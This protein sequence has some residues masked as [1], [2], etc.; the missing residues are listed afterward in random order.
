MRRCPHVT[1]IETPILNTGS[2]TAAGL[3]VLTYL[4][5]SNKLLGHLRASL[6]GTHTDFGSSAAIEA[7]DPLHNVVPIVVVC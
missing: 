3:A 1:A 7:F 5:T 2:S 4:H 6:H